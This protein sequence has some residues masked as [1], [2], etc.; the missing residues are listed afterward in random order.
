MQ[1]EQLAARATGMCMSKRCKTVLSNE[2]AKKRTEENPQETHEKLKQS[3][4]TSS[5]EDSD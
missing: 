1:K 4:S 5:S 3:R 2:L